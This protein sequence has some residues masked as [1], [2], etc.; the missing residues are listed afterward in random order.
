[1]DWC[2]QMNDCLSDIQELIAEESGDV[3]LSHRILIK[4]RERFAKGAIYVSFDYSHRNAEI[5]KRYYNGATE[6]NLAMEYRL[7]IRQ[8]SKIVKN[9][10]VAK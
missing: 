9:Y 3:E 7:S 8:I 5:A 4:M 10:Q 6:R 2:L 1:M